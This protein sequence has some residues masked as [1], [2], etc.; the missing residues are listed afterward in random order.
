MAIVPLPS[1]SDQRHV[2][3][4]SNNTPLIDEVSLVA[5]PQHNDWHKSFALLGGDKSVNAMFFSLRLF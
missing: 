1:R 4:N 2:C 5:Q 3:N